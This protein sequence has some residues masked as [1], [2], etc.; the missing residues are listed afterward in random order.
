MF[1]KG[2]SDGAEGQIGHLGNCDP[3]RIGESVISGEGNDEPVETKRQQIEPCA[4]EDV[5][6]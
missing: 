5:Q 1:L 2:A 6:R 4:I 3:T